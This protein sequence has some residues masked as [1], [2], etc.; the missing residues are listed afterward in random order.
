MQEKIS[1]SRVNGFLRAEGKKVRNGV[2]EEIVLTG[3]G[4]GNWLLCEG[5][6]WLSRDN[7]RF[8]RP[9]RIEAVI[10]ELTGSEYAKDFWER[11][12]DSYVTRAD[13]RC[14]AEQG[15]N[16]VRIPINWRVLMEDDPEIAWKEDGFALIDR[17]LDWCE[18]YKLYAFLDLHGAP[19]GQTGANIDDSIDD[20]A[21]LFVD[22]ESR[23]KC[24]ELW[25]ELARRY[26]DRWIVGGYDLLN[27]PVCPGQGE[28]NAL[29][30]MP[31]ALAG[32]YDEVIKEIRGIDDRHMLSLEGHRWATETTVFYKR[33]D[34]NMVIH[35]HRYGCKPGLEAVQPFLE[36][37]ERLQLPLWLGETGENRAEWYTALFPLCT[38][39]DISYNVWPWKK[40][41]CG[42]SPCS[43]NKPDGWDEILDYTNGGRHPGYARAQKIL[44]EYLQNVKLEN[45]TFYQSV[46]NAVFRRPDC[47]MRATDFDLLPGAGVT[48]SGLREKGNLYDYH[49]KTGMAI[50][51]A[52]EKSVARR[53]VFDSGWDLLVL[54]L[55]AEEFAVY[56]VNEVPD[57]C[58]LSLEFLCKKDARLSVFQDDNEIASPF[59]TAEHGCKTLKIGSLKASEHAKITL[60][61]RS[62][63]VH[64]FR[65]RFDLPTA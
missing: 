53:F 29:N 39:L 23:R 11:F 24:I 5:Y 32:F 38:A 65:L 26:K 43:V 60:Y 50:L 8:D 34:E 27:E 64:F 42:N 2:G 20:M 31:Y 57:G 7:S 46:T 52:D 54:E 36:C 16:S 55:C 18:E 51:P 1:R 40:M 44:D 47:S 19:G 12:R 63:T 6:M 33:Y 56:S 3:W 41:E 9:R 13:I 45:C 62:G 15:Y 30:P 21:R 28:E 25:K 10:R 17:C 58:T 61:V 37:S 4:L 59:L 14:M 22:E 49:T 35:F 48:Y